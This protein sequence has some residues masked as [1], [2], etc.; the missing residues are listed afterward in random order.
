MACRSGCPTQDHRT[1]GECARASNIRVGQV[2]ATAERKWDAELNAYADA[3]RQGV[4]PM[5]TKMHQVRAAMD[6]SERI[7]KAFQP[8]MLGGGV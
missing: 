5:G 1:W 8:A 2:D 4:Q 6:T 3:R 7:G